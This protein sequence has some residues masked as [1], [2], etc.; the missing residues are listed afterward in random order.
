MTRD[1]SVA[2]VRDLTEQPPRATVAFAGRD[3]IDLFPARARFDG[4]RYHFGLLA[5]SAPDLEAH[6]VVL[7]I[8]AGAYWFDLRGISVRGTATRVEPSGDGRPDDLVWYAIAA[9]RILA[10]DYGAIREE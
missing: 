6:E 4:D 1:V 9:R 10:W 3:A 8:D 7:V 2:A 5:G